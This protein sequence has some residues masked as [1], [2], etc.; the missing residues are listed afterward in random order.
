MIEKQA[1][2]QKQLQKSGYTA[3]NPKRLGL[4]NFLGTA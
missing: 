3:R 4:P 2:V 1:L